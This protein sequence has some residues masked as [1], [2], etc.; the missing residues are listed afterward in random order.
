MAKKSIAEQFRD[1]VDALPAES[2]KPMTGKEIATAEV[3]KKSK[4]KRAAK[5]AAKRAKNAAAQ[6]AKKSKKKSRR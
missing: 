4:A 2:N 6:S 1:F 5:V 3:K